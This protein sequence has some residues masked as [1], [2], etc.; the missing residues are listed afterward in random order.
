M[1][2]CVVHL[3][4][5]PESIV[6]ILTPDEAK[7]L[8]S[9]L[10]NL[11]LSNEKEKTWTVRIKEDCDLTTLLKTSGRTLYNVLDNELA[12]FPEYFPEAIGE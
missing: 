4:P 2:K 10:G 6:L 1:T 5:V 11:T 12:K 9:L 7:T 3:T 8:L